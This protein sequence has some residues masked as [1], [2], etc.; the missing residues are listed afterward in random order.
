M[1]FPWAKYLELATSLALEDPTV[2]FQEERYR[3]AISRAYY[4]AFHRAR[5]YLVETEI[6]AQRIITAVEKLY[7]Q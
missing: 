4:A 2:V 1:S 3:S 7:T 5:L 6:V